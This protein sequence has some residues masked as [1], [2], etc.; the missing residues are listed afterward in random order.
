MPTVRSLF[1]V[2]M[3]GSGKTTVGRRIAEDR[4]LRFV[5]LDERLELIFGKAIADIVREGEPRFRRLERAV[6][7]HFL[8]DPGFELAGPWVVAT[9]GGIVT[10]PENVRDMQRVGTVV[11]LEVDIDELARRVGD[12]PARPLLAG[13]ASAV[14]TLA[15]IF[16]E[17]RD[18]Y[19]KAGQAI[20][21]NGDPGEVARR[22]VE[23]WTPSHTP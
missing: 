18:A 3:M 4:G 10:D 2:G 12:D 9:G 6:L 16:A 20:D 23:V 1:L 13:D 22:V 8:T 21:G 14:R 19:E 11:Y 5:D 15:R 17:R 7:Q